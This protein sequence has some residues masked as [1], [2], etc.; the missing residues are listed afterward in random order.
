MRGRQN[1]E[2]SDGEGWKIKRMKR[3]E[4]MIVGG[5]NKMTEIGDKGRIME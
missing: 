3:G 1:E 2:R 4:R 5:E